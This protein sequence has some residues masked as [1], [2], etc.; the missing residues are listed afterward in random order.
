MMIEDSEEGRS[1]GEN[2]GGATWPTA[3]VSEDPAG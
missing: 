2:I 3:L 1:E